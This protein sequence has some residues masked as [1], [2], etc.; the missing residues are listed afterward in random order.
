MV[1]GVFAGVMIGLFGM[2]ALGGRSGFTTM[3]WVSTMLAVIVRLAISDR[4]NRRLLEQ[5]RLDPLT[6]LRSRGAF[7]VDLEG[8]RARATAE[9]PVGFVLLDLNNFKRYNDS[10]GHPAGDRLLADFG[11][12]LQKAIGGDGDAYRIG[13]DEFCMV[14]TCPRERYDEVLGR[15]AA[16]L[17]RS[18]H[19]VD[20][21]A[22]WGI[23]TFPTEVASVQEA[24][25]L[26]DLRMYA[27]KESRRVARGRQQPEVPL[28]PAPGAQETIQAA[29]TER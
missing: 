17:T 19:G 23:A 5:V 7:E 25:R 14:L 11:A 21:S 27:Q 24:L 20:V 6:G 18:E 2:H 1:P 13:G 8:N 22:S 10:F 9:N 4:E 16:A 12:D 29:E 28:E 3:L 15:A 26:A